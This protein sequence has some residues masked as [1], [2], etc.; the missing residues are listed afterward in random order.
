LGASK[1]I[2][3]RAGAAP[4]DLGVEI[5]APDQNRPNGG[6]GVTMTTSKTVI[7]HCMDRKREG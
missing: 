5:G 1:E 3:G 7:V 6:F 2:G 4:A